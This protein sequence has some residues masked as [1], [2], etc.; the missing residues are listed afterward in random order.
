MKI[1][2]YNI[3]GEEEIELKIG[4]VYSV[5]YIDHGDTGDVICE[6][7]SKLKDIVLDEEDEK[8][9]DK[10]IFENGVMIF[11]PQYHQNSISISL[12]D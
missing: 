8:S 9:I 6:F 5:Q 7:K 11:S 10:L 4:C 12:E 3:D 1:Y 2:Y